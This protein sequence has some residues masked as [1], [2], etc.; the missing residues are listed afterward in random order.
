[1][2]V[3]DG[4]DLF[5]LKGFAL[6]D[7]APVAGG[8]ADAEEDRFVLHFCLV[9][10]FLAPR[11]PVYRVVCVLQQIWTRL[12]DEPVGV[13]MLSCGF[14]VS[15][16]IPPNGSVVLTC[17]RFAWSFRLADGILRHMWLSVLCAVDRGS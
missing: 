3:H 16:M 10:G 13:L 14:V 1:M 2:L 15:D 9:Q 11:V 6:H 8:V 7:M 17:L 5:V 4:G 12:V